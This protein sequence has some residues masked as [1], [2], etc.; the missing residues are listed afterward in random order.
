[1]Q[2]SR[3]RT[4]KAIIAGVLGIAVAIAIVTN[5]ALIALVAVVAGI[6]VAV[7]L[8]RSNKEIVRDERI[9]QISGKAASASFYT[10]L[11]LGAAASLGTAL[12]RSQLP[13]NVVFFGAIMG[14]FICAALI[15][16]M[17]F[18]AYF[19]RKL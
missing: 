14:Y 3:Y 8:E 18:Y 13:E 19:S 12:F 2:T 7:I 5:T 1:M 15:L 10:V 9:S 11:I 17:C 4:Y 6:A 16:H